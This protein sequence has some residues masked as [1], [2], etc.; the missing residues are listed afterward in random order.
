MPAFWR[1]LF[2]ARSIS[3]ETDPMKK[4]LIVGL[5]NIG[6]KY[7]GTRHPKTLGPEGLADLT[8]LNN[9]EIVSRA[10]AENSEIFEPGDVILSLR[11]PSAILAFRPASGE[12]I[13]HISGAVTSQHDPDLTPE[14][15]LVV[16]DN[17][18]IINRDSRGPIDGRSRLVELTPDNEIVWAY[19][20]GESMPFAASIRGQIQLLPNGNRLVVVAGAG[21]VFEITRQGELAWVFNNVDG[22]GTRQFVTNAV[23]VPDSPLLREQLRCES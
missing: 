17:R 11:N 22:E 12:V 13:W 19:D 16:F 5:G 14:G 1:S 6:P 4:F 9:I 20:G 2:S 3:S 7:H 10:I 8:H 23:R 15:N 21:T 18:A